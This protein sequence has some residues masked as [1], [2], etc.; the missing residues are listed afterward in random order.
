MFCIITCVFLEVDLPLFYLHRVTAVT[1]FKDIDSK[2][3]L[4][5]VVSHLEQMKGGNPAKS[6][7]NIFKSYIFFN[8]ML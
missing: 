3:D 4:I 8:R 5:S 7:K 2:L 1:T 6:S